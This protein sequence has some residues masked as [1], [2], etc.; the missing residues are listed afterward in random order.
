MIR[1]VVFDFDGTLVDSNAVKR[2]CFQVAIGAVQD[3]DAATALET[4]LA[5]GGDRYTILGSVARRLWKQPEASANAARYLAAAYSRCCSQGIRRAAKR[6]GLMST[7]RALRDRGIALYVN[8][9]TPRSDLLPL[10]R[11]LGLSG[12]FV[13]VY[14]APCDKRRNLR[15]IMC[16]ERLRPI[17]T[18]VIGDGEDDKAAAL[19]L[20]CRFVAIA[21][22]NSVATSACAALPDL[23][24]LPLLLHRR[25]GLQRARRAAS[26]GQP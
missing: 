9:A 10:L 16:R 5:D 6:R 11:A 13:G 26:R 24:R 12:S 22:P 18:V 21:A 19:A 2:D 3:L 23:R 4:A 7:L 14:G 1:C 20:G 15:S 25:L 8:S 17:E